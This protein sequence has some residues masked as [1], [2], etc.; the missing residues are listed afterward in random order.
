MWGKDKN[1]EV[2]IP[3]SRDIAGGKGYFCNTLYCVKNPPRKVHSTAF[4]FRDIGGIYPM[5]TV[6][7]SQS[8]TSNDLQTKPVDVKVVQT[9][10]PPL[11]PLQQVGPP[12][13][14]RPLD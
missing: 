9:P 6:C 4:H 13:R 14:Q 11:H 5:Y 10:G 1:V 7:Y 3:T 8:A 12:V 2:S